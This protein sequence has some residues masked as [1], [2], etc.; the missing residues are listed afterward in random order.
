M[1]GAESLRTGEY[2]ANRRNLFWA[3]MC[4]VLGLPL[5]TAYAA[6]V[7]SLQVSGIA[8][9]DVLES[10]ERQGS[11]DSGILMSSAKANDFKLFFQKQPRIERICFN[12]R[13]AES[14]FE[15]AVTP[16]LSFSG[17]RVVLP[18]T[19]P[20]NTRSSFEVKTSAWRRGIGLD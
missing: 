13:K 3:I 16:G 6:R 11:L 9:W 15:Q 17:D 14:L 4:E 19:S 10:C 5:R 12:G 2:Y 8:V 7:H 20:A 1:P 18:S